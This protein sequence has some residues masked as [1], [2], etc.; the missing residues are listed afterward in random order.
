MQARSSKP[1]IIGLYMKTIRATQAKVPFAY[2][3]Q[4]AKLKLLQNTVEFNFNVTF[5]LQPPSQ[6]LTMVK[7]P[8]SKLRYGVKFDLLF[9]FSEW[10]KQLK[11]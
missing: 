3:V 8:N 1:F 11:T 5:S 2:F 10:T 4:H 7:L 6:L 9:F